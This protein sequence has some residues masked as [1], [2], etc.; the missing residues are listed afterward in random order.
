MDTRERN[1]GDLLC[2]LNF[3]GYTPDSEMP[4]PMTTSNRQLVQTSTAVDAHESATPIPDPS[5]RKVVTAEPGVDT[6]DHS[7]SELESIVRT[8][9]TAEPVANTPDHFSL[10]LDET[11]KVVTISSNDNTPSHTRDM[12]L[13]SALA[14]QPSLP[15]AIPRSVAT[16]P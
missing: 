13:V 3:D 2:T 9:V 12:P 14:N 8:V 1:L 7:S 10:E 15:I 4:R 11:R 6:Q 16:T 5:V